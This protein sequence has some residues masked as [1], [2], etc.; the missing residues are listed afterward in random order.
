MVV[1][2]RLLSAMLFA[3]QPL[4]PAIFVEA[5]GLFLG[6]SVSAAYVPARRASNVDPLI[7]LKCE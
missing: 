1:V 5:G 4:N 2:A 6:V 7:T 3:T